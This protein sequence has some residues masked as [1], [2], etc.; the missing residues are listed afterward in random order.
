LFTEDDHVAHCPECG[1]EL[2]PFHELA[3]SAESQLELESLVEQSP[4]ELRLRPFWD[5]RRGKGLLL[6]CTV[7]G[8]ASYALPWFSQTAPE[9]R[10]LNGFELARHYVGWL[11]GGAVGWFILLP[12]LLTRRT[13]VAM[14]G[15]RMIAAVFASMSALEILVFVN[16]TASRQTHV[17]VQFAWEWGVWVSSFISAL[18]TCA[19]LT[20]GGSLPEASLNR[21]APAHRNA[22]HTRNRWLH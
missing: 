10:V 20:L 19:A 13:I 16:M 8:L 5:M 14:R 1:V 6:T 7:L 4:I 22:K 11:W 3:P 17:L 12:L 21:E 18:G 2:V 15:V 9:A